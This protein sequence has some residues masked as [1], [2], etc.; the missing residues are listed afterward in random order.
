[1]QESDSHFGRIFS[2]IVIVLDKIQLTSSQ[3]NSNNVWEPAPSE[4]RGMIEVIW[5]HWNGHKEPPNLIL[6]DE[7]PQESLPNVFVD[8]ELIQVITLLE[9]KTAIFSIKKDQAVG[10]GET[11]QNYGEN[12]N[13]WDYLD[14]NFVQSHFKLRKYAG[15]YFR[16]SPIVT[17][18]GSDDGIP[19]TTRETLKYYRHVRTATIMPSL[20]R[21][22]R[23]PTGGEIFNYSPRGL[24]CSGARCLAEDPKPSAPELVTGLVT[25]AVNS[26]L[27]DPVLNQLIGN[28]IQNPPV[29]NKN[30]VG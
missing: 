16:G 15:V 20:T 11:E 27:P 21:A 12:G 18:S 4:T 5:C 24:V 25:K 8:R 26:P 9:F 17:N 7:S 28:E 23:T 6:N 1:M 29:W 30:T 14:D 19:G 2:T 13:C 3:F 22:C 10:L